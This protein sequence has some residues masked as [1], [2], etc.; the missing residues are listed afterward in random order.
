ME[1][2]IGKKIRE[3]REQAGLTQEELAERM[4][5]SRQAVSKWE[6]DLSRPSSENLLRLCRML[7]LDWEELAG[8]KEETTEGPFAVEAFRGQKMG[9]WMLA[10]VLFLLVCGLVTIFMAIVLMQVDPEDTG[11]PAVTRGSEQIVVPEG[12]APFPE[13]IALTAKETRNFGSSPNSGEKVSASA[14]EEGLLY[15]FWFEGPYMALY[16]YQRQ[17]HVLYAAYS[18]D[19]LNAEDF[20]VITSIAEGPEIETAAFTNF[21]ALGR[22]GCKATAYNE[23]GTFSWYFALDPNGIPELFFVVDSETYETDIDADGENE[24]ISPDSHY[25]LY[26]RGLDDYWAYEPEVPE[27]FSMGFA[28]VR[29]E[30]GRTL[31]T[32]AFYLRCLYY[33]GKI[34]EKSY[35]HLWADKLVPG[36]VVCSKDAQ[37]DLLCPDVKDT[38]LIFRPGDLDWMDYTDPDLPLEDPAFPT[39]R[40]LAYMALQT[41]YELTGVRLE[42]CY[43]AATNH[44]V[45][46]SMERQVDFGIFLTFS[47]DTRWQTYENSIGGFM[48]TWKGEYTGYSP[49]DP[50]ACQIPGASE[51]ERCLWLYEHARFFQSGEIVQT[52]WDIAT[53]L[54]LE[55]GSFFEAVS[56]ENYAELRG[57]YPAGF[58]H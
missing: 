41:L 54:Y 25:V 48:L 18:D 57:V 1:D 30:D 45:Y 28:C 33:D 47:R 15:A 39:H 11:E 9:K 44:D 6:A 24:I 37:T 52:G 51:E 17:D 29:E 38:V 53:R 26:D 3:A 56:N 8:E 27:G 16:F 22:S 42:R 2:G 19:P 34:T 58:S 23:F 21:A 12:A 20:T 5:V 4:E 40:Q 10:L 46:L 43:A 55:D 35:R 31:D 14:V 50:A 7:E 32:P 13:F 36:E 49:L